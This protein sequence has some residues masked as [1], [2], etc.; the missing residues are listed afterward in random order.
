MSPNQRDHQLWEDLRKGSS[1]A[2]SKLFQ[3]Y[4]DELF[5]YGMLECGDQSVVED[6]IQNLFLRIWKNHRKLRPVD[7]I[8]AYLIASLSNAIR[9]NY[10]KLKIVP[11]FRL[12][13]PED[14]TIA[15]PWLVQTS[16]EEE[17]IRREQQQLQRSLL[18]ECLASLPERM[19][20]VIY[21]RYS[22]GLD[23]AEIAEVMGIKPQTVANMIHRASKKL[24]HFSERYTERL[25]FFLSFSLLFF[26]G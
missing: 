14:F 17:W 5:S 12:S 10:R 24:R 1:P 25:L 21:L 11:S 20:Q 26:W 19:Q 18:Q 16:T 22:S 13:I 4:A 9:D 6:S 8:K 2:L 23:Y 15:D 7:N 3:T